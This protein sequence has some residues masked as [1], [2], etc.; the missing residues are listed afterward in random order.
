MGST[1]RSIIE[2]V[3]TVLATI[4]GSGYNYD[5]SG[6]DQ[7]GIGMELEPIRVPGI[8]LHPLTVATA[9]TPGKTRLRNYDRNFTVQVDVWV[10]ATSSAPGN[11]KLAALDAQ[12]DV[13]KALEN[14][15]ALGSVGVHDIEVEASAYD[16]AELDRPGIGVATLLVKVKYSERAGA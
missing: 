5:F 3:K 10:P 15:R 14:D 12:S 8:Y 16:G 2:R 9:Q 13:M 4:D 11:A 6:S 7:V 1:E